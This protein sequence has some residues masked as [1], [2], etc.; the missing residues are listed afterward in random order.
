MDKQFAW[1]SWVGWRENS[2]A[3]TALFA[4]IAN[5]FANAETLVNRNYGMSI[6]DERSQSRLAVSSNQSDPSCRRS[7]CTRKKF[8][9]PHISYPEP[10][11]L[12]PVYLYP[13]SQPEEPASLQPRRLVTSSV[14]CYIHVCS[15][16]C[17]ARALDSGKLVYSLDKTILGLSERPSPSWTD[18]RGPNELFNSL[19]NDGKKLLNSSLIM[20]NSAFCKHS[21][22]LSSKPAS[23]I[24]GH[25]GRISNDLISDL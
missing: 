1:Y 7:S 12:S 20:K 22:S 2:T 24:T 11:V 8:L 3:N 18:P 21:E 6:K 5:E 25:T 9:R 4:P 16:L 15:P 13:A 23:R 17:H 10:S 19:M 14:C